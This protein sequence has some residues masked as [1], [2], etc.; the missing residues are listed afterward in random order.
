MLV[1]IRS[2]SLRFP[3]VVRAGGTMGLP[4]AAVARARM[5]V[6]VMGVAE[7]VRVVARR[8]NIR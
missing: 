5:A 8:A 4:G 3:N 7:R 6:R 1:K 2:S